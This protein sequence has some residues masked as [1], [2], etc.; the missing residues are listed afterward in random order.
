MTP[1]EA[2]QD[3]RLCPRLAAYRDEV[4]AEHPDWF[5]GAVASF[6][7]PDAS[8]L[9]VDSILFGNTAAES[10]GIADGDD[11][12]TISIDTTFIDNNG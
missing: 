3:C 5:N 12:H 1:P 10:G 2:P 8:L 7:D 11:G 9:I 4:A 6:G